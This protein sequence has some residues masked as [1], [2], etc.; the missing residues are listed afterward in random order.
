MA[1]QQ[2]GRMW[3]QSPAMHGLFD[4][5][6]EAAWADAPVIIQGETGTGKELLAEA[7][8]TQGSRRAGPYVVVDCAAIPAELIESELFGHVRGAFTGAETDRAGAFEEA[9]SGTVFVDEI[10]ELPLNLQPRLLRV[11]E[12]QEVRR[13]G[14]N[15]VRPLDVRVV[16]ATHRDLRREVA[17]GRFR[18]DLYFRLQVMQLDIPPLR[19]RPEDVR[20]LASRFLESIP[21]PLRVPDRVMEQLI[22]HSWPGNVRELR[23]VVE[24]GAA[25]SDVEFRL[26]DDFGTLFATGEAV[27]RPPEAPESI[28]PGPP[29]DGSE[30][31]ALTRP[32]WQDK[33]YKAAREAV[34]A[35]FEQGFVRDLLARFDGNVSKAARAAGI[36]RNILHRMMSRY[37]IGRDDA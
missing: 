16:T 25:L 26:P 29:P 7:L 21:I 20:F 4:R 22:A 28:E 32:L 19:E 35:D 18:P 11:L 13:V 15:R 3:A 1:A 9:S 14:D 24:Q 30:V 34:L 27:A 10:G 12:R 31:G 8:H 5:A 17:E 6:K 33:T 36:H 23:N 2:F 37:G